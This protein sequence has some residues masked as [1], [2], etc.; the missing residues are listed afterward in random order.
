MKERKGNERDGRER[1]AVKG[2]GGR[3]RRE[4]SD[5]NAS[6]ANES[7]GKDFSS[8]IFSP[9]STPSCLYFSCCLSVLFPTTWPLSTSHSLHFHLLR[10]NY[11]LEASPSHSHFSP[12]STPTGSVAY[13]IDRVLSGRNRNAFCA[14]RP[15]GHHAGT[16]HGYAVSLFLPAVLLTARGL[17]EGDPLDDP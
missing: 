3:G 13:A 10:T 15:P 5:Q 7:R 9:Q 16:R 2:R 6:G 4:V 11:I 8:V 17:Q 12:S 14:V 1:E